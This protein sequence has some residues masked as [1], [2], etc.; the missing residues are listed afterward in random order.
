MKILVTG[1]AGFIGSNFIRY[2]LKNK[3]IEIINLDKLT[4]AGNREN[5]SDIKGNDNYKFIQGDICNRSLVNKVVSDHVDIIINFAAE[6]HVDRSIEN[7]N[8]F[9]YTNVLGTQILLDAAVKYEVDNFIQIST[10]EVYGPGREDYFH[11]E[12]DALSPT[13]PYAASKAS[14]DLLVLSY[15]ETYGLSVNITRSTNNYGPYQYPEKVIPLFI[16]N[17]LQDKKVPLY[18]DGSQIR[19]WL[20]VKDHCEAIELIIEKGKEGEI[21]NINSNN[22]YKNIALTKKLLNLLNKPYS[23]INHVKD[24]P[25]HDYGYFIDS[26]KIKK[27]LDWEPEY[28]FEQ[29]LVSTINWYKNNKKWWQKLIR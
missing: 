8:I 21:Y 4:Y 12:K 19:D 18:G 23:E 27:Q 5:L 14:A 11:T 1:G 20:Y 10:D 16:T 26:T 9:F 17:L 25:G 2:M 7:P 24:R 13:N 29:G 22:R 15:Y 3:D 28:D 6:S